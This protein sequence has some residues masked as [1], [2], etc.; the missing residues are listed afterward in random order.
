[1]LDDNTR[2]AIALMRFSLIA[3]AVNDM[4]K[5]K[6]AHFIEAA[7]NPIDMPGYG[8]KLYS[9]KTLEYW[10]CLYMKYGFD[11]LVPGF[12][13]D[14]GRQ[15]KITG[16]A[17]ID[18]I[19]KAA[20]KMP[21]APVSVLYEKL[22]DDRV[23]SP[24]DV[25]KSTFYRFMSGMKTS[26]GDGSIREVKRYAHS[27]INEVWQSDLMYGPYVKYGKSRKQ[28]YLIA[29]LDDASRL[30]VAAQFDLAQNFYALR[31]VFKD[32][33]LKRGIPKVVYTDNGKIYRSQH[34][35]LTCAKLG[36]SLV[37]SEPFRPCGRGY[38]KTS[39]M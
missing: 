2:K 38:V 28:T 36:C 15:R 4:V 29:F 24:I 6:T 37:H 5:N 25:S 13:K 20:A 31:K 8:R 21:K 39:V 11:S 26:I 14:K 22:T 10:Y 30:P 3:P 12:R 7:K 1:M 16:P 19:Q 33:V 32:A 27:F 23:L 18:E 17:L 34:F 35:E 9:Y